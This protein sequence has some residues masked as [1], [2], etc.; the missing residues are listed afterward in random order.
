MQRIPIAVPFAL[1]RAGSNIAVRI[2]M[3]EITM[4]SST[5][6][7]FLL[8]ERRQSPHLFSESIRDTSSIFLHF[9][10]FYLIAEYLVIPL[11]RIRVSILSAVFPHQ[12]HSPAERNKAF[13]KIIFN[14]RFCDKTV[15]MY[16]KFFF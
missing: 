3:I 14:E 6:V 9:L 15:E 8:Q 13:F 11:F 7:K 16:M 1:L 4:R 12:L 10:S 5:I 2:E